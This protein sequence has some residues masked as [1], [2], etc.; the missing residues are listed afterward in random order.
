MEFFLNDWRRDSLGAAG[1]RIKYF[2]YIDSLC[3][4]FK[5]EQIVCVESVLGKPNSVRREGNLETYFYYINQGRYSENNISLFIDFKD[6]K[7]IR[8]GIPIP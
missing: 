1:L 2:N 3:P 8:A 7:V 5:N 6:S 4:A